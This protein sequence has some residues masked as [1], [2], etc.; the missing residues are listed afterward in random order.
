MSA[1]L[2]WLGNG[3]QAVRNM[4]MGATVTQKYGP[5][6]LSL[7]PAYQGYPHFHKG[8]DLVL[9]GGTKANVIAPASGTIE[10]I[11][12]STGAPVG[13]GNAVK[14]KTSDGWHVL[15]GHMSQLKAGIAVGQTVNVGD[16]IGN[17]G[18]TGASTGLHLHLEVTDPSGA[19]VNPGSMPPVIVNRLA[20]FFHWEGSPRPTPDPDPTRDPGT[21]GTGTGSG[22]G[23]GTGTSGTPIIAGQ[24]A[25]QI[26]AQYAGAADLLLNDVVPHL[27]FFGAGLIF[28][29]I[30]LKKLGSEGPIASVVIEPIRE[31][32][33]GAKAAGQ[34]IGS[35]VST[36][37]G[38]GVGKA[39]GAASKAAG[40]AE[41]GATKKLVQG[42]TP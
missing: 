8:V 32:E 26:K 30:G 29:L 38:G 36:V 18:S 35:V 19:A 25:A 16:V 33:A 6:S 23:S 20:N 3:A 4:V 15:L 10:W 2:E 28:V 42:A 22:T 14:I 24:T 11:G 41:A 13:F 12:H 7:E 17:Q 1:I 31:V 39:A 9:P 5:T 34:K 40:A 27:L 21:G 37:A